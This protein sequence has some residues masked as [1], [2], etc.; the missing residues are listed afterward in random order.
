VEQPRAVAVPTEPER[1][2]VIKDTEPEPKPKPKPKPE[3]EPEPEPR[4]PEPFDDP[5]PSRPSRPRGDSDPVAAL[6]KAQLDAGFKKARA[7]INACSKKH[8][9]IEGTQWTVSFD[10]VDGRAVNTKVQPP[11]GLTPLGRCVG[12]AVETN[13]RF[14]TAQEASRAVS[15]KVSF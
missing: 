4:D 15:R 13:A 2:L 10:V 12:T 14:P 3:P 11:H 9:A 7:G 8:G 5:E 1:P 6:S